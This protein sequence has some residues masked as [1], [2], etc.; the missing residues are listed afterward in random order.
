MP[1]LSVV[2]IQTPCC[3][4]RTV[5]REE[6]EAM[7]STSSSVAHTASLHATAGP[8]LSTVVYR[9]RAVAPLSD[10]DL[11]QLV[12]TA[13]SRNHREGI[14]GVV[15][16]DDSRFFQWLEGPT[17]GLERVMGSIR[18]DV[19]HTDLEVLTQRSSPARRF[20]GW[21]M[22][23]AARDVN[24]TVWQGDVLEPPRD[25]L[26]GLQRQPAAAP[27]LLAKLTP[28]PAPARDGALATSLTG[29][30]LSRA[31]ASIL[32]DTILETVVPLLLQRHDRPAAEAAEV[33]KNPR[34]AELAELLVASDHSAS[35]ELI[36]ELRGGD[37]DVRHLFAP[38]FE[39]T[40][41]SLGDMWGNDVCSEF[42]VTL[43]LCRLQTAVRLLG[44]DAPR[45][46]LQGAEPKVLIAPAPGE[47][48]Q[49]VAALDF[50]W[51]WSEGWSPQS[52][53]P[54]DDR[55]LADLLSA[56]WVDVLNLSLSAAFRRE[57]CLPRLTRTIAQARRA[58]HNP[59]LV[60]IVGGRAFFEGAA[61]GQDV[62]ADM[63]SR[64][65][66][67]VDGLLVQR[68][69]AGGFARSKLANEPLH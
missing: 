31:T 65:S 30:V 48:H 66:L 42:E 61:I 1:C 9:S 68:M 38:L 35:L 24:H 25:V 33:R 26:D 14:T 56:N 58:S 39:P 51:L 37:V 57:D 53:Y 62:G 69:K 10:R 49:L 23:L 2:R 50:E 6:A 46:V 15:L 4:N 59:A 41:R 3:P 63:A 12:R 20:D 40:A 29:K 60:V 43:G 16:Y 22:K 8:A 5:Y 18:E 28:L 27:S 7:S 32:K 54:A 11:R 34:T 67:N 47:L 45:S 13:Q 55:A 17:E 21:D 52:E 64:T 19:R 36:R 44:A